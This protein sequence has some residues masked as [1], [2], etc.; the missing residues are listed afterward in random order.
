VYGGE[1]AIQPLG[2]R[3]DDFA[4]WRE[5]GIRFGQKEYW[6]W[7]NHEEA[8]EYQ[9]KPLGITYEQFINAGFVCSGSNTEIHEGILLF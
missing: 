5:L 6:P 3:K 2:E 8:I 7:K 4:I 1:R 9:L